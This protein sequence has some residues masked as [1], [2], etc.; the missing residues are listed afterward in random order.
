M[1]VWRMRENVASVT[2]RGEAADQNGVAQRP[3]R[4]RPR[5]A[6]WLAA[7]C[8][9]LAAG[10]AFN[11]NLDP[12]PLDSSASTRV[13]A[14]D[15]SL[16]AALDAGIHRQPV[17]L[18]RMAP[19]L[20]SA[21]VALEDHRFFDHDGVDVRAVARALRNDIKAGKVVEGG[22]TITQQYVRNVL[23]TGDKTVHRKL[24]EMVLAVE[25]EQKLTKKQILE[26]YLNAVYFGDGSYGAEVAAEHY[27]GHPASQLTLAES[28]TLAGLLQAPDRDDPFTDPSAARARRDLA[29]DA[30]A[31]Y[32]D[33]TDAQARAAKATPI[34]L[35]RRASAGDERA[36]YFV[37]QV[38]QWF[39]ANPAFG[40][41]A[42]DRAHALYQGGYT[43]TTTLDP[44]AQSAAEA[45]VRQILVDR[46]HDPA[47]AVV[48]IEPRTGR[49]V[50][51]VGGRG[52]DGPEAWSHWD[53]AGQA[54]RPMGSTFKPFVLAAALERHIPL[55]RVYERAGA[56]HAPSGRR[57]AVGGAQLREPRLRPDRYRRRDRQLGE[58]RVRAAHARRRP[59]VRRVARGPARPAEHAP[60][61]P[62]RG[63]G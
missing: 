26:R 24:K 12:R 49:V 32:H 7:A 56:A 28:A 40:A 47:A 6:H 59:A 17:P 25:V 36:P 35:A 2:T 52:Y 51:Y 21:V 11:P 5:R 58:H 46:A 39:L 48:S 54:A 23:L 53:L 29:L 13:V 33:I 3:H 63:A 1:L 37:E 19:T 9:L 20:P 41:T 60:P 44:H 31:K 62:E 8:V 14:A 38:R 22:S 42:A 16:L 43:I 27:F 10:C 57:R 4:T 61:I 50:A 18:S 45:A 30:M 55:S 15:G 34:R